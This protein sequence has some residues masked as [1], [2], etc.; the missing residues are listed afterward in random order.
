[1][2]GHARGNVLIMRKTRRPG[3]RCPKRYRRGM[4]CGAG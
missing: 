1:M 2:E 3:R 4:D